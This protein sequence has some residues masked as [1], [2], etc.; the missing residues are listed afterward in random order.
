MRTAIPLLRWPDYG[1]KP[2]LYDWEE[3]KSSTEALLED[4]EA[5]KPFPSSL[6]PNSDVASTSSSTAPYR[7]G[8]GGRQPPTSSEDRNGEDS[9]GRP[10]L[11]NN[12]INCVSSHR[13]SIIETI[14][15]AL[16]KFDRFSGNISF[17]LKMEISKMTDNGTHISNFFYLRTTP[18]IVTLGEEDEFINHTLKNLPVMLEE[19][20]NGVEG[21]GW[22]IRKIADMELFVSR[23]ELSNIG[24]FTPYPAGVGGAKNIINNNS[25]YNYLITSLIEFFIITDKPEIQPGHL[26]RDVRNKIGGNIIKFNLTAGISWESLKTIEKDNDINI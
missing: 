22:N 26:H 15:T 6:S 14:K 5:G 23:R 19:R 25:G 24:H 16:N 12:I 4:L 20:M 2:T 21:S 17:T 18:F 3:V 9:P 1:M 13:Q 10:K 8:G 11:R 7:V